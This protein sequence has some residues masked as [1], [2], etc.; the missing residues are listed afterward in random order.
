M[1]GSLK[2][3]KEKERRGHGKEEEKKL[4]EE[5][6]KKLPKTNFKAKSRKSAPEMQKK[7]K[8]TSRILMERQLKGNPKGEEEEK[9]LRDTN[10]KGKEKEK[11]FPKTN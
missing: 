3:K 2:S 6:E 7:R 5:E 9:K 4:P 10:L 8:R 1:K 11:K